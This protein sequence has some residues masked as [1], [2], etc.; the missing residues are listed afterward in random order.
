M[1]SMHRM[2]ETHQP[3]EIYHPNQDPPVMVQP[4][5]YEFTPSSTKSYRIPDNS[6]PPPPTHTY[7]APPDDSLLPGQAVQVSTTT[8][9]Q[10]DQ[11]TSLLE[12]IKRVTS[13]VE[14]QVMLSGARAEH[15]IIQN[16]NLFQE[17]I[18]AQNKRDL[19]PALMSIPMFTGEDSSQCLDWITRIKN[20]CVQFGR[21]LC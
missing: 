16:N 13:A 20:V 8:T 6:V 7:K 15:S 10:G 21:S 5:N 1:A 12:T 2:E 14:Q 17:L 19:D 9:D 18:K 11:H 4:K 3:S